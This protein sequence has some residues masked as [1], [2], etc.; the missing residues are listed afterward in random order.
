[1]K[2]RANFE[3]S[4]C[5]KQ[6]VNKKKYI[7][8]VAATYKIIKFQKRIQKSQK[9]LKKVIKC[10]A[11]IKNYYFKLHSAFIHSELNLLLFNMCCIVVTTGSY[12]NL[13]NLY[14]PLLFCG[15][16]LCLL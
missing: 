6:N 15:N 9:I 3:D 5:K 16:F 10:N 2:S 14:S 7:I 8:N 4:S 1:M 12:F 13:I 11:V